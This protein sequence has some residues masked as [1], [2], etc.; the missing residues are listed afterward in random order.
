MR[1]RISQYQGIITLIKKIDDAKDLRNWRP[2]SLLC[3][4]YK[5]ISKLLAKRMQ[6]VLGKIIDGNQYCSV[7][8]RSIAQC[9]ML[10]R[11]IMFYVNSSDKLAV[12][13][14]LDLYK[15]FDLVNIIFLLKVMGKIEFGDI[16]VGWIQML[17][18]NAEST[19][20]INNLLLSFSLYLDL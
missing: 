1:L 11:D 14:K 15:V 8:G 20:C 18:I 7:P 12:F 9:N 17:Y 16:F 2:I 6:L 13:L 3:V 5:I 10:I 4:N 19:I